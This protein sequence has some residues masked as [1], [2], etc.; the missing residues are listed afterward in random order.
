MTKSDMVAA[1]SS[2][3]YY[4]SQANGLID[5]VFEI[6]AGAL[7]RG[8]Q[9][10]VNN[11][12]VFDVKVRKGRKSRDVSTGEIRVSHDWPVPL[13][14]PSAKLKETVRAGWQ[15]GGGTAESGK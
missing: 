9:V 12:G 8:E 10:V 4:K 1:L 6:I 2:K 7:S 5:D 11:F 13:L 15:S 3:G 14:R